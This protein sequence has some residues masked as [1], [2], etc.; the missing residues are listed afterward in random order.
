MLTDE[1]S[2]APDRTADTEAIAVV[3]MS[4]RVAGAD[5]PEAFWQLLGSGASA[6]TRDERTGRW[7][8]WITHK[9]AFDAEFFGIAPR[10]AAAMDPQARLALELAWEALE[11]ARL[12]P[13]GLGGTRTG[14]FVG[15]IN[16]DYATLVR[17]TG[18]AA[19]SGLTA[20]GLHR[21]MTANR[22]SYL[23]GLRGPSLTVDCAQSSS[24]VAVHLA[25][26][27]L[28][29]G[30]TEL[31]VATGVN[32]ILAEE[33]SLGMERMGALSADGR[34]YTFDA[35]ANGYVRGEGGA[36]VV[37]K[38]LS[39]A[40]ADG[41]R[42]HCV[43][44][45]G[46]VNNDGGGASLTAPDQAAQE[47]LIRTALRR[48]G[49][50]PEEIGY[51][52]LHGTGTPVGDPIEAAALGAALRTGSPT[53]S[54]TESGAASASESGAPAGV[55]SAD[56][57]VAGRALPVGSAKTNVGHLEGASGIVGLVKTA[58]CL[59]HGELV[60][61][62]NHSVPNPA[63]PLDRLGLTVQTERAPWRAP[64]GRLRAAGVSSFGMGG[65][66]CHLVVTEAPADA[67]APVADAAATGTF[68]GAAAPPRSP[69]PATQVPWALSG[70]TP[71]A[72]RAQAARLLAYSTAH[73]Q[74]P[75]ADIGRS[76]AL[77][78]TAFAHRAVVTAADR[79]GLEA[80]LA[81]LAAGEECAGVVRGTALPGPDAPSTVFVFPGQGSQWPGM[82]REL[83][84]TAPVFRREI[85]A[86]E[87]ALAPYTDWSLTEVLREAEGAPSLARVDVVQPALFAVMVSLAALWRSW[88]VEPAAVVGH[89]QGEIAAAYVS[90]A[91]SLDDAARVVA[92]RSAVIRDR[93]AG[94]GGMA[95]VALPAA[96]VSE[97]L[98]DRFAQVEI[99]VV[100][101]PAATVVCGAP[102]L[103]D[104]LAAELEAEGVR[105]RIIPVDYASHSAYVE[106]I[107][108]ELLDVLA[109][110]TPRTPEI[111]FYSTVLAA[112][113]EHEPLDAS[114]WY[115]NLRGT[116]R[117]QET[118]AA[119]LA[120]G[121]TAFVEPTAHPLLTAAVTDTA[122]PD[123]TV[124]AVGTLR[125]EAGGPDR[126]LAALAEAHTK[127]LPVDLAATCPDARTVDLP[128]YAFQRKR[129][130]LPELDS[131]PAAVPTG[132]H[133]GS[134]SDGPVGEEAELPPLLLEL[135][136]LD[137]AAARR[138][139]LLR[140][141]CAT[142]AA[143]LGLDG[144][145]SVTPAVTFKNQG[146]ESLTGVELRNRLQE[147][148]ALKLPTTL[149]YQW[150]TPQALADH[151]AAELGD[152]DHLAGR[153]AAPAAG[154]P[155]AAAATAAGGTAPD[156]DPI[157]VVG[158]GCRFPGGARTPEDLWRL[159]ASGAD[160]VGGFP[161]DRGWDVDGLYDPEPGKPGK[162]YVKEGGFLY[163]AAEFDAGFFGIS[164]REAVAMD[165]QQ[166]LLL[167]TSWEALERAGIDPA[168]LRGTDTGVF[169]GVMAQDYGPRL[170]EPADGA[171]GYLLTGNT[172]SVA[173][174]R[175]AYTLGLQGPAVTLDTACSSSLVALHTAVQSLRTGESSLAL[176]GGACV[177]SSPGIFV[178]FGHQRGLA[179]DGR[180]KAF[181][182]AA[183]GTSWGEGVGLVVLERLS[184]A[185][186]NGHRVLAVVRGSAVNQDGA[187]NGLSAP[188]GLAQERVIRQALDRAGL[189][190]A[191]VDVAEAH[192]TGTKLG[193]PIEAGA[194]LATYGQGRP[195]GRPLLLGSLKSNIGH[196]QAAAGVGGVIKMV[197][198]LREGL[199]P[200][201][202]HVD[203][204]TPHVDWTAGAVELVTEAVAWP[205]TGRPRRAAVSSFGISGTNAHVILEQA[206]QAPESGAG[207][208]APTEPSPTIVSGLPAALPVSARTEQ[209]LRAQAAR[210]T[211]HLAA[212]ADLTP[213]DLGHSLALAR[214]GF[215]NRAVVIAADRV[216]LASALSAL[217]ADEE[218]P[219]VV[220]GTAGPDGDAEGAVFVFP[221]QGAQW[222]GMGAELLDTAPVFR[223]EIEACEAA[224]APFTDWSLTEVLRGAEG[225]PTLD[226]VDV[227]QP[228]SFAVMV[229]LAAL[230]RSWGVEPAAVVG[231]SQGEIAA[232]YVSGALSLDDAARVVA[233]R[234]RE[235]AH[236]LAGR[237]GMAS[238][239]LPAEEVTRRIAAWGPRLN[240]AAFNSPH[241][242]VLSGEPEALA[243]FVESCLADGGRARI[244]PVDYASHSAYVEEI[245][246][247]VVTALGPIAPRPP[248]I[249]FHS[250]LLARRIEHE[251][252][253]A[254]YWYRN[255]RGT[256]RFQE[257]VA[258]LA[259]AGHRRFIE[260]SPHPVLSSGIAETVEDA[261][262]TEPLLATGSLR[263]DDGGLRRFAASAAAAHV[264]GLAVDWSALHTPAAPRRT[265][266][267]TYAFQR[268]RYWMDRPRPAA[269]TSGLGLESAGHPLLG[270]RLDLPDGGP[271]VFAG[272]VGL[273]DHA[274]LADHAVLG[275]V[276]LPGTAFVDL[277]LHAGARLDGLGLDELV[278]HAP[279]VLTEARPVR[280]QV[281]VAA[282]DATGRRAV[283][284]HTRPEPH[285]GEPDGGSWTRHAEGWLAPGALGAPAPAAEAAWPPAGARP[286]DLSRRYADLLAQG[287]AYG[288]AFQGLTAA[289]QRDDEV[290]AEVT[291]AREL[292]DQTDF[293][294][295]PAALDAALHA[296]GLLGSAAGPG[297]GTP[298][299]LLPFAW[300][301]VRLYAHGATALRVRLARTEG[302]AVRVSVAD[303]AG[304]PV[305]EVDA[306][307]MR[308]VEPKRLAE[309]ARG[310][311]HL[312][313]VDWTPVPTGGDLPADV[314]P[315]VVGTP[316]E[317]PGLGAATAHAGLD[318]LL[319][320]I[321]AGAA[322]PDL[323]LVPVTATAQGAGRVP[324]EADPAEAARRLTRDLL[325]TVQ[326]WL[327]AD[328][329]AG[330]R[331]VVVT[332]GAVATGPED[333]V[334]DLAAAAAWGLIRSVQSEYPD[335]C[336][337]LDTDATA[338]TD[339]SATALRAALA[340]AADRGE[341][342]IV[343]RRGTA[344]APRLALPGSA[345][346]QTRDEADRPAFDPDGT[347]LITGGT[348]TLGTL[349]ARHLVTEHGARRL[350]LTSRQGPAAPGAAELVA[351]LRELG[352]T[353]EV[354]ACDAADRGS[355][356]ATLEGIDPAHPLTA[357]VH[358]A[359]L[360]D[361]ATVPALTAG[362]VDRVMRPKADAAW[363][364]HELTRDRDVKAFVLFSSVAGTLGLGGQAN[365]AAANVF[366][367]SLAHLRRA[368]GLPAVSLAWGL[369]EQASGMTGELTGADLA[370]MARTGVAAL[371]S[372]EGLRLLDAALAAEEALLV[373]AALDTAG[374]R[375]R[376]ASDG[377]PP[378]PMLRGLVRLPG[379]RT[380]AAQ[381]AGPRTPEADGGGLALRLAPLDDEARHDTVLD[382]VRHCAAVVLGHGSAD[383]VEPERAFAKLG[384]DS[385]TSV[386]LRN[387]LNAATGLRL[388]ATLLFDC[389]TPGAVTERILTL[390]APA[391]QPA[392]AA[393]A[394]EP[395][396]EPV[397]AAIESASDDEIFK[398]I[399]SELGIS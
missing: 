31:A 102:E 203:E 188:N 20:T 327:A 267:P 231:H 164:P 354:A 36:T 57:R 358:A 42:V 210:L 337:L 228:A 320:G 62:L 167:E 348:G 30:E 32:L 220:R 245:A 143:V 225:A 106:E 392:P 361:D 362:H 61:T 254:S 49:L 357:V 16:D 206:P 131:L 85:E 237:G 316:E 300:H 395:A 183:D 278:L 87:A 373:P 50:A 326:R 71:A 310:A 34:S 353:A 46:A 344:Y 156:D 119:L 331:L 9:D 297:E 350:L 44:R 125:R 154:A 53:G 226:R 315:A 169:V 192:G 388:P 229:A 375:A 137:D 356:A 121:H 257:T 2:I 126:F 33:S 323:L 174:G 47:E 8:G 177:M 319:A 13:H 286:L 321:A 91:L 309:L 270:A 22:L 394:P 314:P 325:A 160:A 103:L 142:T 27:S 328:R 222:A 293:G 199:V 238:V 289:W 256:V 204:P 306:L 341:H 181:S 389:P 80:G 130:W 10:E 90:G 264:S 19:V 133:P 116:V 117:F 288:P 77:T 253:D 14:V 193:D 43:I 308:P 63:I 255:L 269:A 340:T 345:S 21:A 276:L 136:A 97:R 330:T 178:E 265:D 88:G 218:H 244:I 292:A 317:V 95:S 303:V 273:R 396:D 363:H 74:T 173:S 336:L 230:W 132:P 168:A 7:A 370:R 280:L 196:T 12:L 115:R 139:R 241:S 285:P 221:G 187:S 234:S 112:R 194:L 279:L 208:A 295:H 382:L 100:N 374:L 23:L 67:S 376:V 215:E 200:K 335:R 48:S 113:I 105:V 6:V 352:A 94:R 379:R 17:R 372:A 383:K 40:L 134:P 290:F 18:P 386:E 201:T 202:L 312:Y 391:P 385:L 101:A 68:P 195:E 248:R 364:L 304:T 212:D 258:R 99:A 162:S 347:V 268:E 333:P 155:V 26:E 227:L 242:T 151:L 37:L 54:R 281:V 294:I 24:L 161:T 251:P 149:V 209:A 287:Y 371:P 38:R 262:G 89:S 76:L 349:V 216:E 84:D 239:A 329:L 41:D 98:R 324:E 5:S 75:A 339:A 107:E 182:A 83:L 259:E 236:R 302:D 223:R 246:E 318:A 4:C 243:E 176:A 274:W 213:A 360:L 346:A 66:N 397:L 384:F 185:V 58:L 39:D 86:C 179:P 158:M 180:S 159:V 205:E 365:Y 359:G 332:R 3:G 189:T 70:R 343:L 122:E 59:A 217:A 334:T 157:A 127:G 296:I 232:A 146:V 299:P 338:G 197:M 108:A 111:P 261:T 387:R 298:K 69:A 56:G 219:T 79:A 104:E 64:E 135:A 184:D 15:V 165:P 355:L 110:V 118:V 82:S 252:L 172:T 96:A 272:T 224:L 109:P 368:Q 186:R 141:V 1:G 163:D 277:V 271:V 145:G 148:T 35:R 240:V 311:D 190:G 377:T 198:A 380:E 342:Q 78:R 153:A 124:A 123:L 147:A 305:A 175:I 60:A 233:L 367:D 369:W 52:E 284:V 170:H 81:A 282:A 191:D 211:E 390:L 263:R 29:R 28:R 72:L 322:A 250:T 140:L 73:P 249:P 128:T 307:V 120:D 93:L 45:G 283:S 51:V 214:T 393:G 260:V 381:A 275:T 378:P 55:A 235:I 138:R 92:L 266:L 398:F 351:A 144:P 247:Q 301:G 366:L 129:H 11:D 171:E 152:L 150:P 291:P 114:Y 25:C 399:E 313:A 207:R 166:R 65:T